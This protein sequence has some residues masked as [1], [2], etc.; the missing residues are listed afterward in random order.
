MDE[1]GNRTPEGK[2][3]IKQLSVRP[4]SGLASLQRQ[5]GVCFSKHR[6][7]LERP[8]QMLDVRNTENKEV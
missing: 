4:G 3:L 8:A 6:P 7:A 1:A 5:A 2:A